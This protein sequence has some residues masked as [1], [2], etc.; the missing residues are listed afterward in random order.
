PEITPVLRENRQDRDN[1]SK[2]VTSG[3]QG[4]YSSGYGQLHPIS[5]YLN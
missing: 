3:S 4:R 5:N 2:Y 1:H